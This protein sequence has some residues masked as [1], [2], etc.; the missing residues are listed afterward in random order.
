[1]IQRV[2]NEHIMPVRQ[3]PTRVRKILCVARHYDIWVRNLS[4]AYPEGE[5]QGVQ[6]PPAPPGKSHVTICCPRHYG[7]DCPEKQMDLRGAIA[8]KGRFV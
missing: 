8:S 3:L 4:W 1:M 2:I 7:T 6:I 5:G